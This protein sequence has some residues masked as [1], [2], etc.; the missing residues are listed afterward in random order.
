MQ[1]YN[2][3]STPHEYTVFLNFVRIYIYM[4]IHEH[5]TLALRKQKEKK[6]KVYINPPNHSPDK[7]TYT[8][9]DTWMPSLEDL[10]MYSSP[11]RQC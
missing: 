11:D 6:G 4:E 5:S 8:A 7:Q 3:Y 10:C 9:K 1:L 2:V